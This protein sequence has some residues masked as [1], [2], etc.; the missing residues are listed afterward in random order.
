MKSILCIGELLIDFIGAESG[1]TISKQTSFMMKAGGAPGNVACTIGALGGK[2]YFLGAVGKDGFGDYLIDTLKSFNVETETIKRSDKQTT[3]AF[4]SVDQ[5]GERDFI[6]N[7]GADSDFEQSDM[8]EATLAMCPIVHFGAATGFLEG[9]LKETY[10]KVL[11]DSFKLNHFISFDPNYRTAF[12]E[13][14]IRGFIERVSQFIEKSDLV[15]LSEEEAMMISQTLTLDEATQFFKETFHSVFAI[16][17]GSEGVRIFNK[18]WDIKIPAPKVNV[19]DTTGAGDAFIGAL[20][21]E[22]SKSKEP[23]EAILDEIK[24]MEYAEKSNRIASI[25]CSEYGALTA[26]DKV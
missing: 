26:L 3:L 21:Y 1:K 11:S 10:Y 8:D 23:K 4:V 25:I 17:L 9:Q 13:N 14:D 2:C 16:T 12:W 22:I 19:I 7:R 5:N 20:I 18:S 15:K 6:F 24:M